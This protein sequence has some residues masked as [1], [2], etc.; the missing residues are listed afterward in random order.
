MDRIWAWGVG[1]KNDV[2]L[3]SL[4]QA[5]AAHRPDGA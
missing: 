2:G 5:V 4:A 1:S 3:R